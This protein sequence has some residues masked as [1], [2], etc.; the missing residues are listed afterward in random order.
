[1]KKLWFVG[2]LIGL[3]VGLPVG[4]GISASSK[5]KPVQAASSAVS[6]PTIAQL[7]T[8]VNAER[9]KH[10]VAPLKEDPRLDASA[11]MK[12]N[13]E[14]AYDYYGHISPA[15]S[16]NAGNSSHNY[17]FSTGISCIDS[18]ENLDENSTSPAALAAWIASPAHHAAM[19]DAKYSLTGFGVAGKDTHGFYQFVE[20]FCQ[21]P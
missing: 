3:L 1:M 17:I 18:S 19:I 5:Q 16:P 13:D 11:Q 8:L 9:A 21:T 7:L 10:G 6:E 2:I 15:G 14:I 12:A 20:H 4:Y